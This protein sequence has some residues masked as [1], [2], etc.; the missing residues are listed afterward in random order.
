VKSRVQSINRQSSQ[1]LTSITQTK[2]GYLVTLQTRSHVAISRVRSLCGLLF[3][4][5]FSFAQLKYKASDV[6]IMR[7]ADYVRQQAQEVLALAVPMLATQEP[8]SDYGDVNI[9]D[10]LP[11][12][13]SSQFLGLGRASQITLPMLMS[14]PVRSTITILSALGPASSTITNLS[15][16]SDKSNSNVNIGRIQ[17]SYNQ[18]TM[19]TMGAIE[20]LNDDYDTRSGLRSSG[21]YTPAFTVNTDSFNKNA[22]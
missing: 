22:F 2:L 5:L 4:E 7:N 13:D 10:N 11:P 9:S 8:E 6:V 15:D 20:N 21:R 12:L 1:L 3:T 16:R 18:R 17:G 14:E 19:G